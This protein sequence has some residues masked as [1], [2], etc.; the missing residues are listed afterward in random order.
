M[1]LRIRQF[2]SIRHKLTVAF[3]TVIILIVGLGGALSATFYSYLNEYSSLL[4]STDQANQLSGV[5]KPALDDD[6]RDIVNG[7]KAFEEGRQYELLEEMNRRIST[8]EKAEPSND[9][10]S[11]IE[12]IRNTMASLEGQLAVLKQQI[13]DGASV[14]EQSETLALTIDITSLI[15]QNIQALVRE[16]LI[17]TA[18]K[19]NS[20]QQSFKDNLY[21]FIA[22]ASLILLLSFY[23]AW[24]IARAIAQPIARLQKSFAQ[25]A[26]GN[27]SISPVES[28][29][30]DE[31]GMLCES[32]NSMLSSLKRVI[33]S[34]RETSLHVSASSEHI[35]EGVSENDKAGEQ[36]SVSTQSITEAISEQ[37]ILVQHSAVQFGL[38]TDSFQPLLAKAKAINGHAEQSVRL[39]RQGETDMTAFLDSFEQLKHSVSQVG[40]DTCLLDERIGDMAALLKKIRGLAAETNIL[41]LNAAIEAG[42]ESQSRKSFS[43]IAERVKHLAGETGALASAADQHMAAVREHLHSIRAQMRISTERI[44]AGESKAESANCILQSIRSANTEVQDQILAVNKDMQSAADRISHVQ[45][46][47]ESVQL[48]SSNIRIQVGDIAAMGE[49]QA[50]SLQQVSAISDMLM[51]HVREL[52]RSISKFH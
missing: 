9:V 24:F 11:K 46:L 25:L 18:A 22:A 35:Y 2:Q 49:E 1:K 47:V 42:R 29:T 37:E 17:H 44:V 26:D 16:K 45:E 23:I 33:I 30:R 39:A 3:V 7:Y 40:D 6:I 52:D 34:V 21:L 12:E 50:A 36:I 5:L 13:T 20:I 43:V 8:L 32:Y 51:E 4:Q 14:D 38:L 10:L 27:L 19:A 31:I 28:A 15:E 41:S 48:Q